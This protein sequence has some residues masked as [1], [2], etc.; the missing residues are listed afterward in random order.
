MTKEIGPEKC[1]RKTK[2][3]T[4]VKG[5]DGC[6]R[7]VNRT[8]GRDD[9]KHDVAVIVGMPTKFEFESDSPLT[10]K[11]WVS[12]ADELHR[13]GIWDS[14]WVYASP[15]YTSEKLTTA[16]EKRCHT[17]LIDYLKSSG[18]KYVL[19][20]GSTAMTIFSNGK[21]KAITKERGGVIEIEGIR[22]V[23]I[24]DYQDVLRDLE[25]KTTFKADLEFFQRLITDLFA[26]PECTML[27]KVR[28]DSLSRTVI[29]TS[30][31]MSYDIE[32]TGFNYRTNVCSMI[33]VAYR[34]GGSKNIY[35]AIM[36][37]EETPFTVSA[38]FK[39]K[40]SDIAEV[41]KTAPRTAAHNSKFD[42]GWLQS[43]GLPARASMDTMLA[44]YADNHMTP[45]G[46]KFLAK[47]KLHAP[48]YNEGIKFDDLS[49]EMRDKMEYYCQLDCY[50]T[51]LLREKYLES[52]LEYGDV[53]GDYKKVLSKI[54]MPS[55][56][57]L[58]RI[59]ARGVHVDKMELY[60]VNAR[61]KVDRDKARTK[62]DM[63]VL[64]E[65][66]KLKVPGGA[67]PVNYDSP[68]QLRKLLYG[69]KSEGGF[70]FKP[71]YKERDPDDDDDPTTGKAALKK[72]A[73]DGSEFC[74]VLLEYRD[75][76]KALS[77]FVEPW[78]EMLGE[79]GDRLYPSYR[80]TLA[81]GRSACYDPN[82]QQVSRNKLIRNLIKPTPGW[83]FV[84]SDYSQ[85]ELRVAA[86]VGRIHSML[87]IY[88][89]GGDIHINTGKALAKL[90]GK[91]WDSL[92]KE[93]KKDFRQKAKA[94]NFGF[95]YGMS[96]EGFIEYADASYDVVLTLAEAKNFR[97]V[98]FELYPELQDWHDRSKRETLA[99]KYVKNKFGFLRRLPNVDSVDKKLVS[100]AVRCGYNTPVQGTAFYLTLLSMIDLEDE[101]QKIPDI[102]RIIGQCHD[103]IFF[104][105][106]PK[107][108]E[109]NVQKVLQHINDIMV[110]P[111]LS[112]FDLYMDVPLE[113]EIKYGGCWSDPDCKIFEP[114]R[115]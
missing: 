13:A 53:P 105:I 25:L 34:S 20:V 69:K 71:I 84:E 9:E 28:K 48:H 55:T 100:K 106:N 19:L 58:E 23:P 61:L 46:L 79:S 91:D 29:S 17:N 93:E 14:Q 108:G 75:H 62:L 68:S 12:L 38:K 101:F 3:S 73:R 30:T 57:V 76:S 115:S 42:N 51:L 16:Q 10:A 21:H 111:R 18:V 22:A 37:P 49:D 7:T 99:K 107:I 65:T 78:L 87:K 77:G 1:E 66:G 102:V 70:G 67:E 63:L 11:L 26:K 104:E 24:Y 5:C 92:T 45:H 35:T 98:Y 83:I 113:V 95:V 74:K 82:L 114:E 103:A 80:L 86:W 33:G 8:F 31:S 52:S 41:L 39:W 89:E 85:V 56:R 81:T 44:A 40:W 112:E 6:T 4:L 27:G 2:K 59:E 88:R 109:R 36:Y 97:K 32:T 94:V 43:R 47:W 90:A 110:N 60:G 64:R 50:Y 96:A 72:L 54:L 15:C